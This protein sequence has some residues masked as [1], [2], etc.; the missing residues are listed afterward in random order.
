MNTFLLTSLVSLGTSSINFPLALR[1]SAFQA[2]AT[3]LLV[4]LEA[5]SDFY[6]ETISIKFQSNF[7]HLLDTMKMSTVCFHYFYKHIIPSLH[8]I[9]FPSQLFTLKSY[10]FLLTS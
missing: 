10:I 4:S 9:F 7:V 1:T 5:A 3:A 2:A 8:L 6:I